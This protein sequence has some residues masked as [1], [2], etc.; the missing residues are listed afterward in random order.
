MPSPMDKGKGGG[1]DIF[2]PV[3]PDALSPISL[4]ITF[5]NSD[6]FSTLEGAIQKTLVMMTENYVNVDEGD[7]GDLF[8][9]FDAHVIWA[10]DGDLSICR[11]LVSGN[12]GVFQFILIYP[13]EA[14]EGY[15]SRILWMLK[16]FEIIV[17]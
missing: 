17:N 3:N 12:Y 11:Y 5:D 9:D 15:G 10:Q 16:S 1:A 13:L 8:A 7:T 6:E 4:T 14:A 2:V